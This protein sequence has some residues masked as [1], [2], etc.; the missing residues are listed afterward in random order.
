MGPSSSRDLLLVNEIA[1]GSPVH[2]GLTVEIGIASRR[3]SATPPP[4]RLRQIAR[5]AIP[6]LR[7]LAR[8]PVRA[9]RENPHL[10]PE[11]RQ[12]SFPA[13]SLQERRL[14]ATGPLMLPAENRPSAAPG[15][16]LPP[17][18][19]GKSVAPSAIE[20]TASSSRTQNPRDS[21][22]ATIGM[23]THG[24]QRGVPERRRRFCS[25]HSGIRQLRSEIAR[26]LRFP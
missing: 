23:P 17:F 19:R 2:P 25:I 18:R 22:R 9:R 11:R 13:E 21:P 12:V 24:I 16:S 4:S 20:S 3:N 6:W 14:R 26:Q 8:L 10:P 1:S 5:P 15:H 7:K